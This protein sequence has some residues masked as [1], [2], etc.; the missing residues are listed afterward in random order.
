MRLK[1]RIDDNNEGNIFWITMTDLMTGLV[2]V[3]IV[4]FLYSYISNNAAAVQQKIAK[5][6][7][8]K[9]LQEAL[10][11][12]SINAIIEPNSGVVKISDLELFEIGSYT[13]SKKGKQY[14][15]KFAPVYLNSIFSDK[16]LEKNVAKIIVQGHTD[17][18]TFIGQYSED[19]QYMKNMELSLNR[20]FEVANYMTNTPYNKNNGN[21]LRKMIVVEGASFSDPIIVSGKEDFAKS[22]RVEL[23]LVMKKDKKFSTMLNNLFYF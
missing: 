17:S 6:N 16:Y 8:T 7:A 13:L 9:T 12:Q 3:F 10:N 4:M 18:Q 19:E 11:K 1:P 14:L 5:E 23:K 15:D 2:L 20:A 21:R 22:R